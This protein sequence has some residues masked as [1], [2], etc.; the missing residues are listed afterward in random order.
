MPEIRRA[1]HD[2]LP[3][4]RRALACGHPAPFRPAAEIGPVGDQRFI[5][6]RLVARHRMFGGEEMAAGRDL[7]KRA[8]CC[9]GAVRHGI[10]A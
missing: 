10:G 2:I 6:F 8:K 1:L 5:E 9:F 7:G 3:D 4:A